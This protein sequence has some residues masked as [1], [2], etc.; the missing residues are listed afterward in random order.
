MQA[1]I[2]ET[3]GVL[4]RQVGRRQ[5]STNRMTAWPAMSAPRKDA[6]Y[7]NTDVTE[8]EKKLIEEYGIEC[9]FKPVYLFRGYRYDRA[10][11]VIR[12]AATCS[13]SEREAEIMPD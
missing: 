11:D 1:W 5:I 9:E 8:E 12:Y 2:P 13:K 10:A 6:M 7:K 3:D 4:P